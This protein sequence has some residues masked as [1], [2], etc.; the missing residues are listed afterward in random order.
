M[1]EEQKDQSFVRSGDKV[2][3][4]E[5]PQFFSPYIRFKKESNK[6]EIQ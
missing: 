3:I 4:N 5:L 2:Y 6:P 1:I